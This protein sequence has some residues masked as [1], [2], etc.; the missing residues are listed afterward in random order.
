MKER[1]YCMNWRRTLTMTTGVE[2]KDS[3]P[4]AVFLSESENYVEKLRIRLTL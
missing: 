4:L 2:M 1:E 3:V